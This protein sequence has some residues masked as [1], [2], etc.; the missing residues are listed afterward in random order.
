MPRK[1]SP[2]ATRSTEL[3]RDCCL[4][5]DGTIG[6]MPRWMIAHLE[7]LGYRLID[8]GG[9]N[10]SA[11]VKVS[12]PLGLDSPLKSDGPRTKNHT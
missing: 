9:W 8:F 6:F 12:T 1:E 5:N 4:V 3:A 10:T 11:S 2:N 7:P